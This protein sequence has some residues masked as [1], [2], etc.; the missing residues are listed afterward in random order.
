MLNNNYYRIMMAKPAKFLNCGT[1]DMP[2]TA[3]GKPGGDLAET[4][5]WVRPLRELKSGGPYLWFH[6]YKRCPTCY[7]DGTGAWVSVEMRGD[8]KFKSLECCACNEQDETSVDPD[9]YVKVAQDETAI[10]SDLGLYYNFEV[11]RSGIPLNCP[12]IPADEWNENRLAD[13]SLDALTGAASGGVNTWDTE[14]RCPRNNAK[15]EGDEKSLS[16]Y[17]ELYAENQDIWAND[18]LAAYEKMLSNGYEPGELREGPQVLG[19][20]KATCGQ[21][22][23]KGKQGWNYGCALGDVKVAK[24]KAGKGR[25]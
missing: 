10:N 9:C 20:G 15:E 6:Y 12:G 1:D 3:A 11:G 7:K 8:T 25:S 13:A 24:A 23:L 14:P 19:I 16:D 21:I 17:V 5:W 22:K 4:G 18:F 2:A